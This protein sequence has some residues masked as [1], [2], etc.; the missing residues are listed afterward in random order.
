[1]TV[2]GDGPPDP[3]HTYSVDDREFELF[4]DVVDRRANQL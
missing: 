1:M 3:D 2:K 4:V